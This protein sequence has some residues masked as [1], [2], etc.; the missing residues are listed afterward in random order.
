[1][2]S[3]AKFLSSILG[4]RGNRDGD[5]DFS[6]SDA[7]SFDDDDAEQ[8]STVSIKSPED[9]SHSDNSS[10]RPTDVHVSVPLSAPRASNVRAEISVQNPPAP[11]LLSATANH[12]NPAVGNTQ[13]LAQLEEVQVREYSKRQWLK[14][15]MPSIFTPLIRMTEI[16]QTTPYQSAPTDGT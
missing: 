7:G 2:S 11:P 10:T 4:G 3:E 1:M 15:T 16:V 6:A 12:P 13:Y 8:F 9:E 5:D 14:A